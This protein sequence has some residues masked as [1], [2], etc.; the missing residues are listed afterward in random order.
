VATITLFLATAIVSS[1]PYIG[2]GRNEQFVIYKLFGMTRTELFYWFSLSAILLCAFYGRHALMRAPIFTKLIVAFGTLV[3]LVLLAPYIGFGT[4]EN[5]VLYRT[6][7]LL[8]GQI[9]ET[10]IAL[11][12]ILCLVQIMTF[13]AA[14]GASWSVLI[15]SASRAV[16]SLF[17]K[18]TNIPTR[19]EWLAS[20]AIS[21]FFGTLFAILLHKSLMAFKDL[22]VIHWHQI[23]I[24][25]DI[26]WS[27]HMF[28]FGGNLLNQFGMQ[29]PFNTHL[30]PFLGA[31]HLLA[32]NSEI[33]LSVC[34]FY[35]A[36]SLLLWFV[37]Q[38]IGLRPVPRVI[39][40][41]VV[42]LIATLPYGPERIIPAIPPYVLV[43]QAILSRYWQEMSILSLASSFVFFQLGQ[44][45]GY[46][47]NFGSAVGFIALCFIVLLG[48]PGLAFFS[49]P[50][51]GFYC[52]A[53][54]AT[55]RNARELK[56]KTGTGALLVVLMLLA[57]LPTFLLNLYSYTF[58]AY[59]AESFHSVSALKTS[60]NPVALLKHISMMSTPFLYEPRVFLVFLIALGMLCFV[61]V[62]ASGSLRRFAIAVL[63]CEAGILLTGIANAF[64]LHAPVSLYYAEQ[65]HVPFLVAFF[66]LFL[67][68]PITR[69]DEIFLRFFE[70]DHQLVNTVRT[71]LGKNHIKLYVA[72]I[73]LILILA[74]ATVFPATIGYPGSKFPPAQPPSVKI[75][76]DELALK[77]GGPFR[78]RVL[79][80][81][82]MTAGTAEVQKSNFAA[83]QTAIFDVLENQYG[84]YLGND[85]WVDLSFFHIPIVNE[86][87]HWTSPVNFIFLRSF[88]GRAD[89]DFDKAIFFLRNFHERIARMA[90]IRFVVS[91]ADSIPGG[92]LVYETVAGQMPL[93]L[94]RLDR[95][96]LGQYSPTH[97]LQVATASE[98]ISAMT[99]SSFD[100][101]RDAVV[102]SHVSP[103]NIVPGR[104]LSL[105]TNVGPSI[106]IRAD[107]TGWSMLVLPIEYSHCLRLENRSGLSA[108]LIPVNL[109][110]TGLLFERRIEAKIDYSFGPF[111][112]PQCR[113]DDLKRANQLRLREA[114]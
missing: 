57:R 55:A 30:S 5:F 91:D 59:F 104:L 102:E 54:L 84:H 88:F 20:A 42:A 76:S 85:H 114:L 28:S 4:G 108:Q 19:Q 27:T 101:E 73:S 39:F 45:P 17:P 106:S 35:F 87:A 43:S 18:A 13:D 44:Y 34:I 67:M 77:D 11:I 70:L 23:F 107:S 113:G 79:A 40:T 93:R 14:P 98:A 15:Q 92:T 24:D 38:K 3:P 63:F 81:A 50:I 65:I 69:V 32:P 94:Y 96:N 52:L 80:L 109:Q 99:A 66:V 10:L 64:L 7:G 74:Y 82:A 9:L 49:L 56:W 62:R 103:L 89:D 36:L 47:A 58:G 105:K 86:F 71:K 26:D 110:Q 25:Y 2:L 46:L 83:L 41:G 75:L 60:T 112:Q 68:M 51:I 48:F 61:I 8:D 90:G 72:A 95:V 53:F 33:I 1:A 97:I 21:I 12:L 78:G 29:P 100:P 31:A 22:V 111:D 6:L 37:A 16:N